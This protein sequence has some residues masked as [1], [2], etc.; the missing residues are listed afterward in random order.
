MEGTWRPILLC[1]QR[2]TT[3]SDS[4]NLGSN[5]SSPARS[6]RGKANRSTANKRSKPSG[7]GTQGMHSVLLIFQAFQKLSAA[8]ASLRVPACF[9]PEAKTWI[10][11]MR[12]AHLLAPSIYLTLVFA[13]VCW[14]AHGW[15]WSSDES[16]CKSL[17][18]LATRNRDRR[19]GVS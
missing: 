16:Q 17:G 15:G 7:L 12:Q 10:A 18:E 1:D 3:D 8:P 4:E 19:L 14:H 2:R 5:P 6:N 11:D 13:G 9:F